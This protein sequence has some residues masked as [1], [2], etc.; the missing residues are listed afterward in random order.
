MFQCTENCKA[1]C[2]GTTPIPKGVF[3]KNRKLMQRKYVELRVSDTDIQAITKDGLCIFLKK[4][5]KC[6]I[7]K[8]R[9]FICKMY[10]TI[11]ELLC[12][13]VDPN[14]RVRS[15]DEIAKV[16]QEIKDN[17]EANTYWFRLKYKSGFSLTEHKIYQNEYK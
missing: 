3:K 2:C 12:P 16:K 1:E 6:A 11:Q 15:E 14:G 4:D 10:G 8:S 13:Y 5:L 9:P 7:Y 17:L